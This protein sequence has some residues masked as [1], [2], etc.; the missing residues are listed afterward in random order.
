MMQLRMILSYAPYIPQMVMSSA[1]VSA[2]A[3]VLIILF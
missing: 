2:R 1:P 3:D